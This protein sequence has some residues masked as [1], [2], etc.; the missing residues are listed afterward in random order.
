MIFPTP[1]F[2]FGTQ[3]GGGLTQD[4]GGWDMRPNI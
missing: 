3:E 4:L 2:S 1:E